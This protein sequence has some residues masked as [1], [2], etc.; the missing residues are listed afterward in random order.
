VLGW[1][2]EDDDDADLVE[3]GDLRTAPIP[4]KCLS[5]SYEY[6]PDGMLVTVVLSSGLELHYHYQGSLMT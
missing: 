2:R 3:G 6:N 5:L 4:T 1:E